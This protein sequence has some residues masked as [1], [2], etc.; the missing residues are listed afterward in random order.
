MN[1]EIKFRGKSNNGKFVYGNYH[2]VIG[3]TIINKRKISLDLH[4][5]LETQMPD[6]SGWHLNDSYRENAVD[7]NTIGQF[8]GL[9]DKNGKEIYEG[10]ILKRGED[11]SFVVWQLDCWILNSYMQA[12]RGLYANVD[13]TR[14]KGFEIAEVIGNIHEN[15]ELLNG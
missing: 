4:Y 6:Y 13:R 14:H 3:N 11:V 15:P 5:I 1:R 12:G 8:T 7:K 2:K 9:K 10:D